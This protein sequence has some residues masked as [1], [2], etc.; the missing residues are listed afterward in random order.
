M[1]QSQNL[2]LKDVKHAIDVVEECTNE[3]EVSPVV[4][5]RVKNN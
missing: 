1:K 5:R 4:N 3:S 2:N